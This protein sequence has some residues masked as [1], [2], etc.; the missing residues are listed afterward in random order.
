MR[1]AFKLN[2]GQAII[3]NNYRVGIPNRLG[4]II[5]LVIQQ[6]TFAR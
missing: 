5:L 2:K 6:I 1:V 3:R 4:K